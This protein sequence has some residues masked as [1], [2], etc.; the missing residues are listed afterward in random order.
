MTNQRNLLIA[1]ILGAIAVFGSFAVAA[2][3][4][5]TQATFW[6][7]VP[8]IV[9]ITLALIT[10]EVFP[11]LFTGIFVGAVLASG[12]SFTTTM[13][14]IINEGLIQAVSGTAGIF[15][16]LVFLGMLVALI[17]KSGGTRAF[18]EWAAQHITSRRGAQFATFLLGILIF[19]DDYFNCLTVGSVMKPVTDRF[20][21]SRAKLAYII[22]ATAAPICMI[23][24]I[25]SWAAAVS[26][27]AEGTGMS[28]ITMFVRAIPYNFY[29]ILTLVF[30]I[31]LIWKRD[32]YGLMLQYE[33]DALRGNDHSVLSN[34]EVEVEYT[35]RASLFDLVI[36]IIVLI[37]I[38][39]LA[40]VY[41]GGFFDPASEFSGDF[42]GAFGNTDATVALPWGA[43]ITLIFTI[44]Y[45]I[46]RRVV[47]FG[48]SMNCL[49]E[50][51]NSMVAAIMILTMATALKNISNDLLGSADYVAGL[52]SHAA[53]GLQLF[54]PVVIFIVAALLAFA[55]GTSWGTF[56]IL[57][58]I[59][60]NMFSVDET[61]FFIGL[62]AC[63]AGAVCGDHCSPISDTTIMS[64]AG[65][66][67]NH[68]VH[69]STQLPYALT[70][71][72]ISSVCYLLA[73][74]IQSPA[75]PL[76]AGVVLIVGTLTILKRRGG[77][78]ELR[79][80]L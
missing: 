52:M 31:T 1:L 46:V 23:A 80:E 26:G 38:S 20:K 62:S 15:L 7:L 2:S 6:A 14:H 55:T 30:V 58:P 63:L 37:A 22:D 40:L 56:G 28:G 13:D 48:E 60:V 18:G 68:V 35:E 36:P 5:E 27:Y 66:G 41:V 72:G 51:F 71:A 10:K 25:S 54:L 77:E 67:C 49:T 16:F 12:G 17:N 78:D 75:I 34:D 29:S 73:G 32:D 9:A 79:N 19:I 64:S 45:L 21:I 44:A 42:I 43:L 69:V 53:G 24:P 11:S 33:E 76:I 47:D 61:I 8:P 59:V 39:V 65:A 74:F 70:V 50:G 57:I 3:G 4:I